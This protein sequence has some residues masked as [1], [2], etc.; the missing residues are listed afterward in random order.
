MADFYLKPLT[1]GSVTGTGTLSLGTKMF[2]GGILIA[3]GTNTASIVIR[4]DTSGGDIIFEASSQTTVP[5]HGPYGS[6][7]AIHYTVSGTGGEFFPY[8]WSSK[9]VLP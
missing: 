3:D 6:S 8:E 1:N 4:N 9:Q 5:I 7:T 2:G